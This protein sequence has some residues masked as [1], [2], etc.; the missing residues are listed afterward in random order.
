[1]HWLLGGDNKGENPVNV[2]LSGNKQGRQAGV[3]QVN[4]YQ[5][6]REKGRQ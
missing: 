6:Q 1:M 2:W 5:G 4:D 3:G